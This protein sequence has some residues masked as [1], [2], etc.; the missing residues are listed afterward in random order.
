MGTSSDGGVNGG[1][2]S[3]GGG[4]ANGTEPA[5]PSQQ[6]AVQI[7]QQQDQESQNFQMSNIGGLQKQFRSMSDEQSTQSATSCCPLLF[8]RAAP[9]WWNPE[10]DSTILEGQY[11]KSTF[12][13]TTRRFQD[14]L[15]YLLILSLM[16]A[17]YFPVMG[18]S[19]WITFLCVSLCLILLV[20]GVLFITRT[21]ILYAKHCYKISIVFSFVICFLSLLVTHSLDNVSN[22]IS[23]AGLFALYVTIL[24]LIYTVVPLPLY[25][26]LAIG[27]TYTILFETLLCLSIGNPNPSRIAVDVLLHLCV[28]VIG[29][30]I[31][32]TSQVKNENMEQTC[33]VAT[34]TRKYVNCP[35]RGNRSK[36][37]N[38]R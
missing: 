6:L 18:T 20:A 22:D 17:I 9:T 32:I 13:R 30:H 19:H 24:M 11:W 28:H 33:L 3:N 12:P 21:N 31:L 4:A 27:L 26:V 8:E 5:T 1:G 10:F 35:R 23:S 16:W 37:E 25:A 38:T 36:E 34:I 29:V 14:G 2:A 15:W 7:V